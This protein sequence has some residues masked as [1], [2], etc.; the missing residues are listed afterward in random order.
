MVT[1]DFFFYLNHILFEIVA[2]ISDV[3]HGPLVSELSKI[4][5]MCCV[6]AVA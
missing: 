6:K 3:N 2:Q 5:E 4:F 1:L